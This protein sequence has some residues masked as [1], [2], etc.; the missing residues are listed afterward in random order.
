MTD[1]EEKKNARGEN[2]SNHDR[3]ASTP[4]EQLAVNNFST[5]AVGAGLAFFGY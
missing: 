1:K 2:Q 5:L 4:I 3:F